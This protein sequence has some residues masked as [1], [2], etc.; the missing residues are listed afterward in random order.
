[1]NEGLVTRYVAMN[2]VDHF[3]VVQVQECRSHG[4]LRV[5]L[6]LRV[7]LLH[8]PTATE[9]TGQS[10]LVCEPVE[11]VVLLPRL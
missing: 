10:I 7:E 6:N 9:K 11:R 2:V 5:L 3:E 1:M 4:N 8:E